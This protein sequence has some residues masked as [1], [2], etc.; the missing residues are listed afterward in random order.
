MA[1]QTQPHIQSH[2]EHE[3]VPVLDFGS[4]TAQ[5]ICRRV[6]DAGV[7]SVLVAPSIT[8]D[9]LKAMNPKGIILSGGPSSVT[10]D[11]APTMDPAI[12]ELGIPVLG[13]CYGMQL[14]CHLLGASLH[15]APHREYGRAQLTIKS[16]GHNDPI[17]N[18]IPTLTQ[19]WM[20]HGDQISD[21]NK[22]H[23]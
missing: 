4:Q 15:K 5:L 17:F 2:I 16:K 13:I 3:V 20:S 10:D 12:L 11:G 21:L 14:T 8:A 18:A 6:R 19:V 23:M 22:A 9:E 1:D 7:F